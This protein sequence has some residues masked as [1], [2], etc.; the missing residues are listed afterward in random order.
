MVSHPEPSIQQPFL[1]NSSILPDSKIMSLL[2]ELEKDLTEVDR[3]LAL[4][5]DEEPEFH[6]LQGFQAGRE[7]G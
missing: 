6:L 2:K 4:K 1:A 5:P 3:I 7:A